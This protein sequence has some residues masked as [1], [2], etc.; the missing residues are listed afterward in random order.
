MIFL[1]SPNLIFI[2]TKKTAGTSIEIALSAH[3]DEND[4][5]TPIGNPGMMDECIRMD[6]GFK[7]PQNW[8][9]TKNQEEWYRWQVRQF[10][11][12]YGTPLLYHLDIDWTPLKRRWLK[13]TGTK[14]RYVF[15]N[16]MT[17]EELAP[18]IGEDVFLRAHK[19]TSVRHPYEQLVSHVHFKIKK[20][21]LPYIV[22][23]RKVTQKS[24]DWMAD[25]ILKHEKPNHEYYF[26][27][28]QFLIEHVVRYEHMQEDLAKV[29]KAFGLSLIDK[30]PIT[31]AT[32]RSDKRPAHEILSKEQMKRCY[33]KS[34][35]EFEM[36]GYNRYF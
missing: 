17:A 31:K 5:I 11:K 9:R 4:I 3:A 2:K 24:F 13:Y 20:L 6:M 35:V 32:Y 26:Y 22:N 36:F 10:Y 34:R 29:E 27:K 18:K 12:L 30:L 21:K 15:A 1:K 25:D 23:F 8:A 19:I 28:N 33:E 7:Q 16:H 14:A